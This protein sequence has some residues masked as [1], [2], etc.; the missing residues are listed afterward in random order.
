MPKFNPTLPIT[1][2]KKKKK[3]ALR[4]FIFLHF[5]GLQTLL[6]LSLALSLSL[7]CS[8]REQWGT[9]NTTLRPLSLASLEPYLP[10]PFETTTMLWRRG[11]RRRTK[12]W[13]RM[14]RGS[15]ENGVGGYEVE[16]PP[17]QSHLPSADLACPSPISPT[18]LANLAYPAS[19]SLLPF[20]FFLSSSTPHQSRMSFSFVAMGWFSWIGLLWV[21]FLWLWVGFEIRISGFDFFFFFWGD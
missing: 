7:S 12:W 19:I 18:H 11:R 13:R 8:H 21:L 10:S 6:S 4:R 2:K 16:C 9:T 20:I 3:K 17:H 15:G 1:L 14:G 5:L